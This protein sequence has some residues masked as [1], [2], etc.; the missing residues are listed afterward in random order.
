M[1]IQDVDHRPRCSVGLQP[2]N[3]VREPT[4]LFHTSSVS[5]PVSNWPS[6]VRDDPAGSSDRAVV[7]DSGVRPFR[8]LREGEWS[9]PVRPVDPS[10][11]V[12][13][14]DFGADELW[15]A[16]KVRIGHCFRRQ[17]HGDSIMAFGSAKGAAVEPS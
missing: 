6:L 5:P 2:V 17:R 3:R 8:V 7:A 1:V 15:E 14:A 13:R 12:D 10:V 11:P 16:K 4:G 9:V